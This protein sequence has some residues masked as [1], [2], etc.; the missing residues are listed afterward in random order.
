MPEEIN[1]N[2][3]FAPVDMKDPA[4][5]TVIQAPTLDKNEIKYKID[6]LSLL[7]II[8]GIIESILPAYIIF[9]I[10]PQVVHLSEVVNL[11][12]YNPFSSY[13]LMGLI[14]SISFIQ[15][16]YGLVL[17]LRNTETISPKYKLIAVSLFTIG[18]ITLVIIFPAATIFGI[19][20]PINELKNSMK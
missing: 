12:L 5:S 1:Q 2:S 20:N 3:L 6:K 16:L 19:I 10:I 18:V 14:A 13:V 4:S 9:S 11:P 8:S 17:I 7:L 15:I